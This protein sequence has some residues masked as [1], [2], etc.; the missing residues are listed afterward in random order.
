MEFAAFIA[1]FGNLTSVFHEAVAHQP[2]KIAVCQPMLQQAVDFLGKI[3]ADPPKLLGV[4]TRIVQESKGDVVLLERWRMSVY[5][6]N[7]FG[8]RPVVRASRIPAE[9]FLLDAVVERYRT[10]SYAL[11]AVSS[12]IRTVE[13]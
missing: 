10:L 6:S 1:Q 11:P 13:H 3:P 5:G 8:T 9:L 2:T 12:P 7:R 4:D